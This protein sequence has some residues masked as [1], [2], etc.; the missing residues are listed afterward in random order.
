MRGIGRSAGPFLVPGLHC[1][2]V[3]LFWGAMTVKP[4]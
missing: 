2:S 3:K 1:I 4:L